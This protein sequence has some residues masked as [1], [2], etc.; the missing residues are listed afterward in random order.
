MLVNWKKPLSVYWLIVF[1]IVSLYI[2]SE[3][4][5]ISLM[6]DIEQVNVN[7]WDVTL[8]G[9]SDLYLIIYLMFPLFLLKI[10][11]QLANSFEYSQLIRWGSFTKWIL[12]N[13]KAFSL[14]NFSLLILWNLCTV[15]ISL[16]LPF[17]LQWSD[18]SRLNVDGND[19]LFILS[20]NFSQPLYAVMF[21]FSLFFLTILTIQLTLVIL[22]VLTK[23]K[24]AIYFCLTFLYVLSILSF[25]VIPA[26]FKWFLLPNYLSLFHGTK[27]FNSIWAQFLVLFLLIGIALISLQFIGRDFKFIKNIFIEKAPIVIFLGLIIVSIVF[28]ALKYT[29]TNLTVIDLFMVSFFGT[30]H[31]AFQ[32]LSLSSYVIV[33]IGFVY[34]VQLFLQKQ[35]LE[36]S[37][38]SIIRYQSLVKWFWGWFSIILRNIITFL[39]LLATA[40][41]VISVGFGF[42]L[43]LQSELLPN[44]SA[45]I[46]SYHFFVNGFLQIT[47]YVLLVVLISWITKDVLRSFVTLLLFILFMFPGLNFGNLIPVG[48]NSM[49]YLLIN[50]SPYTHSIVLLISVVI[51][52]SILVY[53]LGRKDFIL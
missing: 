37:H 13:L 24:S 12:Q 33:F 43:S 32:I 30:T 15:V 49:G 18:F 42:S 27:N 50:P 14:F 52:L 46:F 17:S 9:V 35:L 4:N 11:H 39:L 36:L 21:Q 16:G 44:V 1:P 47:F 2:L 6:A 23:S 25:K 41:V 48:L 34:F 45:L 29:D 3:R 20:S 28:Q 19:I 22:F 53:F 5:S 40:T 7:F 26:T 8:R 31:E 10:G 38:Y 51:E